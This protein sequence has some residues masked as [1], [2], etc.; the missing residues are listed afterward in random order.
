MM[1]G[2]SAREEYLH[3]AEEA[4]RKKQETKDPATKSAWER[5]VVGY[6]ELAE[7]ARRR[8]R[9]PAIWGTYRA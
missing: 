3:K 6:L 2:S 5:V 9:D 7:L 8:D 4:E 1:F